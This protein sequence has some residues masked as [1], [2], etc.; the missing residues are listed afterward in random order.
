VD[1]KLDPEAEAMLSALEAGELE[2]PAR[3]EAEALLARSAAA[4]ATFDR[5]VRLRAATAALTDP[6]LPAASRRRVGDA[7]VA[8]LDS[9][10]RRRRARIIGAAALATMAAAAILL[11]SS[12]R[13]R[14]PPPPTAPLVERDVR[15][16]A[17]EHRLLQLGDRATAFV[18]ER[19]EVRIEDDGL[20]RIVAGRVRFVVKPD[21]EH[22]WTVA[23][24]AADAVVHGT[25]FDVDVT[26]EVTEVRVARGEVE[27]RNAFGTRTLWAGEVARAHVGAA[28]RRIERIVPIV[29]EGTPEIEERP[30]R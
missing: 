25:E 12:R 27:V 8:A 2:G 11:G 23:T 29:L 10:R 15:T 7:V 22:P 1:E 21:K 9:G 5:L 6:T 13:H 18:G 20:P 19:S 30:R 3:A 28:P 14:E 26:D 24:A 16:A 4:R 17:G